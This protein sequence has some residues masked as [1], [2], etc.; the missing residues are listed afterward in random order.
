[1]KCTELKPIVSLMTALLLFAFCVPVQATNAI[2]MDAEGSISITIAP[3]GEPLTGVRIDVYKVALLNADGNF[4]LSAGFEGCMQ[5]HFD[6]DEADW[7]ALAAEAHNCA[8]ESGIPAFSSALTDDSETVSFSNLPIGIYLIECETYSFNGRT[9][10]PSP[11]IVCIPCMMDGAWTY[12][13]EVEL[14]V[15]SYEENEKIDIEVIKIWDDN[16]S[17]SRPESITVSL[18]NGSELYETVVLSAENNWRYAWHEL[19]PS[20]DWRVVEE[21]VPSGYSVTV[22]QNVYTFVVTNSFAGPTP[23]PTDP[24]DMPQTGLDWK[25][26]IILAVGA[27][28]MALVGLIMRKKHSA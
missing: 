14:K 10:I 25:P 3:E 21:Y 7:D 20:P 8:A 11:A 17:E 2:D 19:E 23:I 4:A 27:V 1:M 26:A 22:E 28:L 18:Y 13:F 9:Y 24:P 15:S 5:P 16:G 12:D 6:M